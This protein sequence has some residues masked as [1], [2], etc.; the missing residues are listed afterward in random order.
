[1]FSSNPFEAITK[2]LMSGADKFTPDAA[3]DA[4]KLMMDNLRMWGDLAQA[5]AQAVKDAAMESV[6]E[7]KGIREPQAA[8]ETF[9]TTA[10]KVIAMSA[11]HLQEVTELSVEQFNAGVDLLQEKHPAPDAFAPVAKGMKVAASAI[12]SAVLSTLKTGVSAAQADAAPKKSR[13]R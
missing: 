10:Q 12:E 5:Q 8:L 9:K 3:Q 7:I 4:A 6:G 1:M 2:S 13:S 11:K